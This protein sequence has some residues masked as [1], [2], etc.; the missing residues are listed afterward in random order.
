[1]RLAYGT[2][3]VSCAKPIKKVWN[4]GVSRSYATGANCWDL[5]KMGEV[6]MTGSREGWPWLVVGGWSSILCSVLWRHDEHANL[7]SW[8]EPSQT[9]GKGLKLQLAGA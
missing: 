8:S 9:S 6:D 1:M 3:T 2:S 7:L 4:M 5:K